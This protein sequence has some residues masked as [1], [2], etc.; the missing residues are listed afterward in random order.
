MTFTTLQ[1]PPDNRILYFARDRETFSFLSHF[2]PSP[3]DLDGEIWPTVEH[4]YQAQK[5]FEPEYRQAIRSASS[6]GKA[7]RLAAPPN[8]P[9]RVSYQSWFRKHA[10]S[11]RPDW[12]EV[13]LEIM[14]RADLAKFSQNR[15]LRAMLLVTGDSELLEDS[16]FDS[17]WGV[18]RD[19]DGLN[20]AGR[21]L[22]EVRQNV[23]LNERY[24]GS[25]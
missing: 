2:H 16:P 19:G 6:P 7:K 12:D 13:K 18:G 1:I 24:H 8:A 5:S 11:P 4:Y 25:T 14:R 21:V 20:W 17:F 22:M 10:V 9:R 15:E 23:A 3:I